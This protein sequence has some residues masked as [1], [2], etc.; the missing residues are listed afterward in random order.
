MFQQNDPRILIARHERTCS[1]QSPASP[2]CLMAAD[3]GVLDPLE[4]WQLVGEA[5]YSRRQLYDLDWGG[6]GGA[7]NLAFMR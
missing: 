2:L 5:Y 1:L 3:E 7:M 4:D 6:G